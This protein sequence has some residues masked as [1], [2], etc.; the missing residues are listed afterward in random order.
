VCESSEGR[1]S[2]EKGMIRQFCCE[3]RKIRKLE[4][5]YEDNFGKIDGSLEAGKIEV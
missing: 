3:R 1:E 5:D 4:L 2:G